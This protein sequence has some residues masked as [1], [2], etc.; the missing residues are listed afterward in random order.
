MKWTDAHLRKPLSFTLL[1]FI[2]LGLGVFSSF[3]L[4]FTLTPETSAGVITVRTKYFGMDAAAVERLITIPIEESLSAVRGIKRSSA[5]SREGE[6]IVSLTLLEGMDNRTA[7][8]LIKSAVDS[9]AE[10]FP[11]D[12]QES[13]LSYYDPNQAPLLILSLYPAQSNLTLRDVRRAAEKEWKPALLRIPG[14][15]EC[16]VS[17]GLEEET[18]VTADP[19]RLSAAGLSFSDIQKA[20]QENNISVSI[21]TLP[22]GALDMPI[23]SRGKLETLDDI[24]S[25]PLRPGGSNSGA[26]IRLSDVAAV[27]KRPRAQDTIARING[28]ERVT[29]YI[30]KSGS[31]NTLL[32]GQSIEK[33]IKE[34]SGSG[35]AADRVYDKPAEISG[36]LTS[37][38]FSILLGTAVLAA[39]LFLFS[40]G[41]MVFAVSFIPIPVS[42]AVTA[43][44]AAV[45]R[46]ELDSMIM[47]GIALGTGLL[48]NNSVFILDLLRR[49]V[50]RGHIF[51]LARLIRRL[52][53]PLAASLATT[54]CVFLPIITASPA[55]R[56]LYGGF[57]LV[58]GLLLTVSFI[59]SLGLTPLLCRMATLY[60]GLSGRIPLERILILLRL[61]YTKLIRRLA[62]RARAVFL[63]LLAVCVLSVL[64]IALQ[65]LNARDTQEIQEIHVSLE[66]GAGAGLP[67]TDRLARQTE[68]VLLKEKNV[69]QMITRVE[70]GH[71]SFVL[72]LRKSLAPAAAEKLVQDLKHKTAGLG[73]F[74][75]FTAGGTTEKGMDVQFIGD[76]TAVLSE[77]ARSGAAL[78]YRTG[79]FTDAVLRFRDD[80]PVLYL[81]P[82]TAKLQLSGLSVETLARE[83]RARLFGVIAAKYNPPGGGMWDVRLLGEENE[84]SRGLDNL[85]MLSLRGTNSTGIP[86][87]EF[88]E[89]GPTNIQQSLYRQ[90]RRRCQTITLTPRAGIPVNRVMSEIRRI[91]NLDFRMPAGSYWQFDS[92]LYEAA[93][94]QTA[95]LLAVLAAIYLAFA[96]LVIAFEGYRK[97][98]LSLCCVLLAAP[99]ILAA[100]FVSGCSVPPSVFIA[101]ILLAGNTVNNGVMIL[102]AGLKGRGIWA[103]MRQARSMLTPVF[104]TTLVSIAGLLPLALV[105]S[106]SGTSWRPFA[107]AFIGGTVSSAV[108]TLVFIPLTLAAD[109]TA[110]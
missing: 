27:E 96:A 82:D 105:P 52:T 12:V 28:Q 49:E 54:L 104:I 2:I 106:E 57:T 70:K 93:R 63:S 21:G 33:T 13:E 43:I 31:G 71:A 26:P 61:Y 68:T 88:V 37:L 4:R 81:T 97:A 17:G 95:L 32:I 1:Y 86:L 42:L 64:F 67:E 72:K 8:L 5:V 19:G 51:T 84:R 20:L 98:F 44:A 18:A 77:M 7:A 100:L 99:G 45:F 83:A 108:L 91:L 3:Q 41:W 30:Q 29:I 75:Y 14:V 62:P 11:S 25:L 55:L 76:D 87:R 34:K 94:G 80:Y 85:L 90:D 36:A 35:I 58:V 102:T 74:L 9:A 15:A 65:A 40:P 66:P 22:A 38:A 109:R 10:K 69:R 39:V 107:L 78:L 89:L 46:I 24:R 79:L 101:A 60:G 92:A 59:L 48:V 103:H 56:T 50:R 16:I 23:Y 53:P 6:S 47:S 73:A 110:R